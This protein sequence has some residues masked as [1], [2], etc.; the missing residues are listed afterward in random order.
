MDSE[1]KTTPTQARSQ[2]G[3]GVGADFFSNFYHK[4]TSSVIIILNKK[5][6]CR[7][8]IAQRFLSLNIL[9]SHSRSFKRTLLSTAC[10]SPY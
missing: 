8:E 4:V 10:V 3:G 1:M 5:L 6:S 7:R 9:L 2:G